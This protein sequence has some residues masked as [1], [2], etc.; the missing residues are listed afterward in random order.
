MSET[1]ECP[2]C[3]GSDVLVKHSGRWGWFVS[4]QACHAVGPSA[5]TRDVAVRRWNKR[6]GPVQPSLFGGDVDE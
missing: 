6:R 1:Q 3:G 2:F 4:C 5:G